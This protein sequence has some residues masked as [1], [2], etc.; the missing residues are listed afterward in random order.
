MKPKK[1]PKPKEAKKPKE[2]KEPKVSKGTKESKETKEVDLYP[3]RRGPKGQ[4]FGLPKEPKEPKEQKA[5]K[6]PARSKL[7]SKGKKEWEGTS[8]V[9]A[10]SKPEAPQ[11][12]PE[13]E[14]GG[15]PHSGV[16]HCAYSSSLYSVN[17]FLYT[18]SYQM[19]CQR[20]GHTIYVG[21]KS[22]LHLDP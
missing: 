16:I 22:G 2:T 12:E 18:W 6:T 19:Y 8:S 9:E 1:P 13:E 17:R 15:P 3:R 5:P 10:A 4:D 21:S 11:A 14:K 7:L 20:L